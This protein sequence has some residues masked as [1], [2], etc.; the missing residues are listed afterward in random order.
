[1]KRADLIESLHGYVMSNEVAYLTLERI[2]M[3]VRVMYYIALNITKEQI[4]KGIADKTWKE[5]IKRIKAKPNQYGEH[6]VMCDNLRKA[7]IES[8]VEEFV[9]NYKKL[10]S[11]RKEGINKILKRIYT[12]DREDNI[13]LL[14]GKSNLFMSGGPKENIEKRIVIRME[15]VYKF[16]SDEDIKIYL[17]EIKRRI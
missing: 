14:K 8:E 12:Q 4:L 11:E 9:D 5:T 15:E 13:K 16:S 17:K 7:Y 3:S 2:D 6:V 10:H 1:M